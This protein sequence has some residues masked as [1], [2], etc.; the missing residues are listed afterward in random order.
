MVD[1]F[2]SHYNTEC[3][4][5]EIQSR[6]ISWYMSSPLYSDKKR[7]RW[8]L[9]KFLL[10]L[11]MPKMTKIMNV[12]IFIVL[13]VLLFISNQ[14]YYCILLLNNKNCVIANG[15]HILALGLCATVVSDILH[16]TATVD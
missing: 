6:P 14:H 11:N 4:I 3:F 12:V 2:F 5:L 16:F 8:R 9:Q 7:T 1:V 10:K 13:F 15:T